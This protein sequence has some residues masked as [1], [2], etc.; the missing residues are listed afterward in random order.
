M[1]YGCLPYAFDELTSNTFSGPTTNAE[2]SAI[3]LIISPLTTLMEDQ[4]KKFTDMGLK[5]AFIGEAQDD[6]SVE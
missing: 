5:A 6:H 3:V 4:I 1:C 2:P